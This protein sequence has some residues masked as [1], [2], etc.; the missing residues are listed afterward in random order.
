MS[1]YSILSAG[2][3]S[4]LGMDTEQIRTNLF[5]A[6]LKSPLKLTQHYLP[7]CYL[8]TLPE[9]LPAISSKHKKLDSTYAR[10]LFHLYSQIEGS[11]AELKRIFGKDRIAVLIGTSTSG[12]DASE[13]PFIYRATNGKFPDTYYFFNQEHGAGSE[14]ISEIAGVTG[15]SYSVSTACSSSAKIFASAV[16]ILKLD[17]ADAVIVG[18]ADSLCEMTIKGFKSLDLLSSKIA[19]PMSANRNGLNIGEGGALFTIVKSEQGVKILGVGESSD[20]YHLSAPDP[21]G[22]GAI[23][24]MR[25]A[26]EQAGQ[27]EVKYLNFHGTGTVLNDS[28]ESK[29]ASEVL[30]EQV[31]CSS[32][33]PLT[34]H[35]LGGC[36]AAEIGFCWLMLTQAAEQK[37]LL[38]HLWDGNK[39]SELPNLRLVEHGQTVSINKNDMILT[40]SFAFGGSNC[41]VAMG[42]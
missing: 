26:M 14:L 28:M 27:R 25:S 9:Q 17:L 5:S 35:L 3:T 1:S 21:Q 20:A 19:N 8:G 32:T 40:N 31:F 4:A 29:A 24:A 34:G 13:K 30:G 33:K 18:G 37:T 12:A 38:P 7:D 6:N 2:M 23:R 16:N 36:G 41:C 39:D 22:L 10:I 15:P 42:L 11:V